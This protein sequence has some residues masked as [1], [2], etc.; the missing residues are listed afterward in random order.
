MLYSVKFMYCV[1]G[2]VRIPMP[3]K[4]SCGNCQVFQNILYFIN[5]MY[6]N[7]EMT[8]VLRDL[9]ICIVKLK[10]IYCCSYQYRFGDIRKIFESSI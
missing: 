1:L 3:S 7:E 4:H 5:C 8:F 9:S 2:D 10:S 6:I